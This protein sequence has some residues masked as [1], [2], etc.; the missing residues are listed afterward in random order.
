MRFVAVAALGFGDGGEKR[1]GKDGRGV[2]RRERI[3]RIVV[4]GVCARWC[5]EQGHH[6]ENC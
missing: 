6:A 4:G 5:A 3:A 1:R 2:D